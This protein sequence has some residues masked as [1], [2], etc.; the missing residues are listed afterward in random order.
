[1]FTLFDV[2]CF[3]QSQKNDL[4]VCDDILFHLWIICQVTFPGMQSNELDG[5]YYMTWNV[6]HTYHMTGSISEES[7]ASFNAV[8][9]ANRNMLVFH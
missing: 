7:N 8:L 4:V 9:R 2:H 5:L 6:V 1:M 3:L